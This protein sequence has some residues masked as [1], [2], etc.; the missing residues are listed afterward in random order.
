MKLR[1]WKTIAVI[2]LLVSLFCT[3]DL[4]MNFLYNTE[5]AYHDGYTTH[6]AVLQ[7]LFNIFGDSL[8][9]FEVFFTAFECSAWI[10]F[11]LMVVN[12]VLGLY[13]DRKNRT[14]NT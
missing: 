4:G 5:P 13:Q 9:S 3:M 7:F 12:V 2:L 6:S 8:W 10:T 11:A 14:S 1:T